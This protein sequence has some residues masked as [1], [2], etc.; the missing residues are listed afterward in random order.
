M[1]TYSATIEWKRGASRFTDL[2]YPRAHTWTFDGGVTLPASSS[3]QHVPLPYSD[4]AAVDPEEAY[5]AA[6]ASCHM[7]TFLYLAARR[8]FVVASYRDQATGVMEKNAAGKEAITRITLAPHAVF[9]GEKVAAAQD[10]ESLHHEAHEE[11][12]LANSVKTVIEIE[13]T[14]ELA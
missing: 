3:P 9:A 6:L 1:H 10:V 14:W 12:Y 13:G 8:G 4:P 7:L 11:C 2:R 5:V